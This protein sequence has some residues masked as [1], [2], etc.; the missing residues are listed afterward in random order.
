MRRTAARSR[1][2]RCLDRFRCHRFG[3]GRLNN[4]GVR[5]L[6]GRQ[7]LQIQFDGA[8]EEIIVVMHRL[9]TP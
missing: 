6:G 9:R 1:F 4:N 2:G 7:F 3:R 8:G 5:L